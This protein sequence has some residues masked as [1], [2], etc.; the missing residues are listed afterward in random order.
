M[1]ILQYKNY[2]G[3]A[4]IDTERMVCKGKILFI[5][6]LVTY[7]AA[8]PKALQREFEAAVDDYLA[9]CAELGREP[10]KPFHGVFN[11]RVTPEL[12]RSAAL[13]AACERVSLNE[14][15]SRAIAA[16]VSVPTTVNHT[17]N[18]NVNLMFSGTS[19]SYVAQMSGDPV[20]QLVARHVN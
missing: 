16:Y 5:K 9:T 2:E 8:S 20:Q 14:I 3:S 4:I 6:D 12:H 13:K 18:H 11:V 10:Q 19:E 7:E 15:V 17:V 1:D